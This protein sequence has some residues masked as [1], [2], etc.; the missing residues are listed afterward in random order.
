MSSLY[1]QGDEDGGVSLQCPDCW[2]GGR[3]LSYYDNSPDT[4]Y[5]PYAN[6]DAVLN[7]ATFE[8][9]VAAARDHGRSVH[10]ETVV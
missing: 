4:R 7:V 6:D 10:G 3:P 1:L 8:A 2:D 5:V 9:L